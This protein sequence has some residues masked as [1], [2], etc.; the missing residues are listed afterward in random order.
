MLSPYGWLKTATRHA[1]ASSKVYKGRNYKKFLILS[2]A[3][4]S[5]C[6]KDASS[7]KKTI[8]TGPNWR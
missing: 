1:S 4:F 6:L 3:F 8:N 7:N 2:Q 5:G